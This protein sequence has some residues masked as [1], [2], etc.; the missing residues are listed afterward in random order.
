MGPDLHWKEHFWG[1]SLK[2]LC[3]MILQTTRL[4]SVYRVY[5]CHTI[6]KSCPALNCKFVTGFPTSLL[7]LTTGLYINI[8][9]YLEYVLRQFSPKFNQLF[10]IHNVPHLFPEFHENA[11]F[12]NFWVILSTNK[13]INGGENSTPLKAIVELTAV[14]S[15]LLD[16]CSSKVA[17]NGS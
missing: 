9:K 14:I 12:H 5:I 10:P 15:G 13:Q 7:L 16:Y 1:L 6:L 4:H 2:T 3:W 17:Y 8:T 11:W